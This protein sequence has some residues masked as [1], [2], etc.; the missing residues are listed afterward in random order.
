[1]P[2]KHTIA[3]T[4]EQR[5]HLDRFTR[6][7]EHHARSIQHARILLLA[8][9]TADKGPAWLDHKIADALA[10][11][12]ATVARVRKRFL[13]D[14]LDE[15]L[16]ARKPTPGRPPK[17]DGIAEA[18]LVALACSSPPQGRARWSL[19]LL[20]DRFVEL[21]VSQGHLASPV[22]YETVRQTLKKTRSGLTASNSG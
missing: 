17:I 13:A 15:A 2:A 9:A 7:G 5:D 18:H 14:G 20:A 21:A 10:C 16:R 11:G 8:D 22:S 3:L 1:M 4:D 6:T 12:L 19:R